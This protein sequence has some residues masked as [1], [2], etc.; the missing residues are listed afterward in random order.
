MGRV[1]GHGGVK[2]ETTLFETIKILKKN[3]KIKKI[4]K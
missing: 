4:I 3:F 1:G 2:M